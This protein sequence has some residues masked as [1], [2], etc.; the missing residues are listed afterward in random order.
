MDIEQRQ[1]ASIPRLDAEF[2]P[3]FLIM[4]V[5][6]GELYGYAFTNWGEFDQ[7]IDA[8]AQVL[9]TSRADVARRWTNIWSELGD[10]VTRQQRGDAFENA[11][12]WWA[13]EG[14]HPQY[15]LPE[16]HRHPA[17]EEHN[18]AAVRS[19][20]LEAF[21]HGDVAPDDGWP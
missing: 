8:W 14:A 3:A 18:R 16:P 1:A 19:D 4:A 2:G 15:E 11:L 20:G 7:R 21:A 17:T 12:R 9:K 10:A 13:A 5:Y 6:S